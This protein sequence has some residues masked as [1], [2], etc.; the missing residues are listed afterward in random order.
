MSGTVST[1]P[2]DPTHDLLTIGRSSIDLY[3]QDIGAPFEEISGFAAYVGGCPTN[4]AV[5]AARLGLRT[6]LLT[7]VG[8]DRV[9]DFILRFLADEGVDT[10][11]VPRKPGH[12]S[13]AVILGIE[14]P[15]RFPLVFYRDNCADIELTIDDVLAAPVAT[16][17]ALLITGTGLSKEPSRSA[18]LFAAGLARAAGRTVAL[19]LD[20]RADQWH[21]P[22]AFGI[23]VRSA[24]SLVDVVIGT[25]DE[26]NASLLSDPAQLRVTGSQHSDARVGGD[27]ES[28]IAT[29][30]A[31]GP[32]VLV[33]KRGADGAKV[34]L[35]GDGAAEPI[36]VPGFP[37]EV[38]NILGAG[39]AFA[40]GLLFG[41]V[42]G[43]DWETSVRLAN[44]CGAIVVTRPGC[45]NFT[46][47]HAEAMAFM[48]TYGPT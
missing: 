27:V 17:R 14:P 16:S 4:V 5:G 18:T 19:D 35:A 45:A 31:H 28:A 36:D 47:T 30:L 43:H 24:L 21:D 20:F 10:A 38:Q 40:A 33:Q 46:P 39:D 23:T 48:A 34:H 7:A 11:A 42:R 41:M 25:E 9:G 12:R 15:D 1:A 22:R 29:L 6:A 13:S 26:I 32:S 2:P 3:S 8:D 37:V 44:A